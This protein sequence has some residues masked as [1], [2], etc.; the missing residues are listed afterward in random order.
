MVYISFIRQSLLEDELRNC[1]FFSKWI[2]K[3][4]S[5]I[6][7][8]KSLTIII[9]WVCEYVNLQLQLTQSH[10]KVNCN[11]KQSRCGSDNHIGTKHMDKL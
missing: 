2:T 5:M 9:F 6:E 4:K 3:P 1:I 10:L 7:L 8:Q 11:I